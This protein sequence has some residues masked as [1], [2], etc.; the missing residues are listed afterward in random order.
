MATQQQIIDL[1]YATLQDKADIVKAEQDGV[2]LDTFHYGIINQMRLNNR[3]TYADIK[4]YDSSLS[5]ASS[6]LP[7]IKGLGKMVDIT[8]LTAYNSPILERFDISMCTKLTNIYA[9]NCAKLE[10]IGTTVNLVNL[11][12]LDLSRT[13][14]KDSENIVLP[15]TLKTL[16]MSHCGTVTSIMNASG[17]NLTELQLQNNAIS[18]VGNVNTWGEMT[19]CELQNNTLDVASVDRVLS[20][21]RNT[22]SQNQVL[23]LLNLSGNVAPTGGNTNA[24]YLY[25]DTQ[26]VTVIID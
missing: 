9:Q 23:T 8:S 14:F 15:V 18:Y 12:N 11:V 3:I 22:Y 10:S 4:S 16:R 24:D 7:E 25:L 21:L 5:L 6:Y 26:G 19:K 17:R 13:A 20:G 2:I 1:T